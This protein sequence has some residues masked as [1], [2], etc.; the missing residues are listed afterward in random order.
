MIAV[1]SADEI[2]VWARYC[3]DLGYIEEEVWSLWR[4]EYRAIARL[5]QALRGSLTRGDSDS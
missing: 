5:L 2:R 3:F 4:D 1:G